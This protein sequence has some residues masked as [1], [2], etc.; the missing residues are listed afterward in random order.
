M[1]KYTIMMSCGHEDT[2]ALFGK[3][4]ERERKIEYYKNH[5]LCKGCYKKRMEEKEANDLQGLQALF[6]IAE[7]QKNTMGKISI[8]NN[9]NQM[10]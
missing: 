7:E 10:D 6:F 5:G 4:S 2:I 3:G 9:Q 8:Q 1:A